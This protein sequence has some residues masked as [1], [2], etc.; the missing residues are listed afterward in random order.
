[1]EERINIVMLDLPGSIKGFVVQSI[2]DNGEPFYTV[3]INQN[4]CQEVQVTAMRHEFAHIINGDFYAVMPTSI[5][6]EQRARA[7]A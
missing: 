2:D 5:I 3:C 6:E 7:F 4:K 1:M